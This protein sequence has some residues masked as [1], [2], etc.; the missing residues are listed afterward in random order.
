MVDAYK[1]GK[2]KN[3]SKK[4]KKAAE[5]MTKKEVDKFASTKHKGLPEKVSE[6][7]IRITEEDLNNIIMESVKRFVNEAES[8]GWVVDT[9]EAQEA[10]NLAVD[11]MGEENI[12]HQI[13]RSLADR[14]LAECLAYI[15]RVMDFKEWTQYKEDK[16]DYD[17]E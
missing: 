14:T 4:I 7:V 2:L 6:N 8:G 13:V 12:N 17:Y 10:Y 16:E 9:S 3:P 11:I 1:K 5:D 15:F